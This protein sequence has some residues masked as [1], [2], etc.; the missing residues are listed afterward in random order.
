[1]EALTPDGRIAVVWFASPNT[2]G[3]LWLVAL[4]GQTEPEVFIQAEYEQW[5]AAISPDGNWTAFV[6]DET[7]RHEVYV[8]A[9][10]DPSRKWRVSLDGGE[11]P[12]WSRDGNKV[13]YRN[14]QQ[15]L[16]VVL[17]IGGAVSAG[18]PRVLFAGNYRNVPGRSY[19][20]SPTTGQF[21]VMGSGSEE[22]PRH[23]NVVLNW[24]S[25]LQAKSL[26]ESS[27]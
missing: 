14:G 21:L 11:E 23:I 2:L 12:V 15:W 19:A 22:A 24:F 6:S 1:M 4:D 16:A 8:C 3:D 25:E 5:G 26:L 20:V 18:T 13:Y 17:T 7:G 9:F 10:S 27:D